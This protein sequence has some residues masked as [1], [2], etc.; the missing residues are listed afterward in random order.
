MTIR[1]PTAIGSAPRDVQ[2]GLLTLIQG[3]RYLGWHP[4]TMRKRTA[5]GIIKVVVIGRRV[6]VEQTELDAFVER[7]TEAYCQRHGIGVEPPRTPRQ[8]R[9]GAEAAA[10]RRGYVIRDT[11]DE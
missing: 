7:S 4:V 11:S 2:S 5:K 9:T 1:N 10:K 3:A 6:Y 8:R